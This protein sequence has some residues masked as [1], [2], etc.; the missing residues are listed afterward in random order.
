MH[1][2]RLDVGDVYEMHT[3]RIGLVGVVLTVLAKLSNIRRGEPWGVVV[4]EKGEVRE[5]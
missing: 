1:E 2:E 4:Y 3:K 5:E